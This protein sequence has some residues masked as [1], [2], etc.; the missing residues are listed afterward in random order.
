MKR[1]LLMVA[2]L[3]AFAL[4]TI[5]YMYYYRAHATLS[6]EELRLRTVSPYYSGLP[7]GY[8]HTPPTDAAYDVKGCRPKAL[9]VGKMPA[10][11]RFRKG[12]KP[13][14]LIPVVAFQI[15][16]SGE[17]VSVVLKQSSGITDK[18]NAALHWVKGTKYNNR[19]G[20]GIVESEV[21]V[22]IDLGP[23]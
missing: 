18:D 7:I 22:T 19:P 12:E 6:P 20:C 4:S 3:I 13:T 16:E 17:V 10:E 15:L 5:T 23:A 14:G 2:A 21:G 1:L 11:I 8:A 9:S